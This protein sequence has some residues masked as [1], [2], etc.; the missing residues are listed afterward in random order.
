VN[1]TTRFV[2]MLVTVSLA[3][4]LRVGAA[5]RDLGE[6]RLGGSLSSMERQ[7][8]AAVAEEY[9]FLG[10]PAEVREWAEKGRLEQVTEG[11]HLALSDVSFPFAQR[12]VRVFVE[13]IAEQYHAAVGERLVITSLVRPRALQP[14][15]AHELSVHPAGMAVDFRVPARTKARKWLEEQLL[16]LERAGVLDVTRER[17]PPH[18]HVA[19]YPAEYRAYVTATFGPGM[20]DDKVAVSKATTDTVASVPVAAA[21]APVVAQH[22]AP[23]AA[24]KQDI[25]PSAPVRTVPWVAA[26]GFVVVTAIRRRRSGRARVVVPR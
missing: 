25:A 3:A 18:Y 8:E 20:F 10:T 19:V 21:P 4:P 2:A 6:A 22:P 26:L 12:E 16:G 23:R 14:A 17:M 1:R 11:P 9:D 15:N 7:H 5:P 13:R 24:V